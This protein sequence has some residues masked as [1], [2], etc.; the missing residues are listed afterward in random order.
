MLK[1]VKNKFVMNLKVCLD[2]GIFEGNVIFFKVFKSL[3][4]FYCLDDNLEN[5]S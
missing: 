4:K 3:C 2:E 5:F 1:I